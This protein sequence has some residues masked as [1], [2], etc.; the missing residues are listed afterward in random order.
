MI[1]FNLA[2]FSAVRD[3]AVMLEQNIY[4]VLH[5]LVHVLGFS[6]QL[7]NYYINPETLQP[8]TNV[9]M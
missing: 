5:E 1:E 6:T 9:T 8:L 7:Y 4:T 2:Q 3:S